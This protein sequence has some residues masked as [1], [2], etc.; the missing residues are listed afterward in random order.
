MDPAVVG[1]YMMFKEN[2][3][4]RRVEIPRG[5]IFNTFP[6]EVNSDAKDTG[7]SDM[8]GDQDSAGAGLN[9][10]EEGESTRSSEKSMAN[11]E[12]MQEARDGRNSGLEGS[13]F[14][15]HRKESLWKSLNNPQA[16]QETVS[17]MKVGESS[18]T[19]NKSSPSKTRRKELATRVK[20][21][22]NAS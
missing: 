20:N 17:C 9:V 1:A 13:T 12:E 16:S 5:E 11:L 15:T 2:N 4:L 8:N 18:A 6:W 22:G 10:R 3:Y 21:Q 14:Y 19:D 7:E